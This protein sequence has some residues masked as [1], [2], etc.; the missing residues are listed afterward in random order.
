MAASLSLLFFLSSHINMGSEQ[1]Q[2]NSTVASNG[3]IPRTTT[4]GSRSGPSSQAGPSAMSSAHRPFG[5]YNRPMSATTARLQRGNT[6]AVS[7]HTDGSFHSTVSVQTDS[8]PSSPPMSVC[9]DS[10]L[11]YISY[12]DKPIGGEYIYTHTNTC[13]YYLLSYTKYTTHSQIHQN[14][15][16]RAPPT[17]RPLP[18]LRATATQTPAIPCSKHQQ[19]HD[20]RKAA[21]HTRAANHDR[22]P[23]SSLYKRPR[24][25]SSMPICNAF[26]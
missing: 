2:P 14:S 20:V 17:H 10:D 18:H 1:S 12:T 15:A 11:P 19:P 21:A 25:K 4:A 22:L 8:R 24:R 7:G 23:R 13:S 9:S 16:I 5:S 26:R 3:A 6:I